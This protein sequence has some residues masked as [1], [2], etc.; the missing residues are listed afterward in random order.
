MHL[1]A[2]WEQQYHWI[3]LTQYLLGKRCVMQGLTL[4]RKGAIGKRKNHRSELWK[5]HFLSLRLLWKTLCNTMQWFSATSTLTSP[6]TFNHYLGRVA[7][8]SRY[9]IALH[10]PCKDQN[11][12]R[13][14]CCSNKLSF[15]NVKKKAPGKV[16]IKQKKC[17]GPSWITIRKIHVIVQITSQVSST[18]SRGNK[19]LF[20]KNYSVINLT[21]CGHIWLI[22]LCMGYVPITWKNTY[23]KLVL[24]LKKTLHLKDC[25]INI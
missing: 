25:K 12:A 24:Q 22:L 9:S 7:R 10:T 2:S 8:S 1:F 6:H 19:I 20:I 21:S 13:W 3:L 17:R 11:R 16:F 14:L 15:K 4:D 23:M 5:C 18:H